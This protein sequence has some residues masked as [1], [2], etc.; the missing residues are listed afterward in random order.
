MPHHDAPRKSDAARFGTHLPWATATITQEVFLRR[1]APGMRVIL[2]VAAGK[3]PG[4]RGAGQA[5][6]EPSPVEPNRPLNLSGGAAAALEF[7]A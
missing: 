2:S 5:E 3:F 7:D 4:K 6:G 1:L